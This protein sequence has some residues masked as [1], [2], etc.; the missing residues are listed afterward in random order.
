M[1]LDSDANNF[2]LTTYVMQM[3]QS[4]FCQSGHGTQEAVGLSNNICANIITPC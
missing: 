4:Q 2:S 1:I 3:W